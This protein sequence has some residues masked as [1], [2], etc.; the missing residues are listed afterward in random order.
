[1]KFGT[2]YAE[3][4]NMTNV[5]VTDVIP[6]VFFELGYIWSQDREMGAVLQIYHFK[7][8]R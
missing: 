3:D 6:V 1:M 4:I 2:E 5:I 8:D 7:S